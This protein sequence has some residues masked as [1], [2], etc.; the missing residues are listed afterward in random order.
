MDLLTGLM[1]VCIAVL[2]FRVIK[3]TLLLSY[4]KE[5]SPVDGY[6][7]QVQCE[8][9]DKPQ[10]VELLRK[11]NINAKEL[12]GF[13]YNKYQDS[14]SDRGVLSRNLMNR[15]RGR[16]R[17]VETDPNNSEGDTAYVVDKG[18]LLSICIR[19]SKN[20]NA[21]QFHQLRFLNFVLI[22]ELAHIASNVQDHPQR[23]WEVFKW[24][25]KEAKE[26][27]LW[28]PINFDDFPVKYCGS[29][30]VTYTPETDPELND[31]SGTENLK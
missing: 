8:Y 23:F 24:M 13:L 2:S 12:I 27:G 14:D 5:T 30:N 10:A 21:S 28:E 16:K 7:Y 22:H 3:E 18:W 17:L 11:L 1:I 29:L 26:I 4:C 15:Y 20:K 25:L 19:S 9:K 6:Q 31:I